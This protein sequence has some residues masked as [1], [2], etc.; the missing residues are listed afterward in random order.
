MNKRGEDRVVGVIWLFVILLVGLILTSSV[1]N[2]ANKVDTKQ[3]FLNDSIVYNPSVTPAS[4]SINTTFQMNITKAQT[5]WRT[6]GCPISGYTFTNNN[7]TALTEN[8][9]YVF[10]SATGN[11][12][13]LNTTKTIWMVTNSNNTLINYT[14][15]DSGYSTD[16]ATQALTSLI[17]TFMVVVL[18]V[19]G[20]FAVRSF[21]GE[22]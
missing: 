14:Y 11:F 15:C 9:D 20:A 8:T 17:Q 10:T 18:L 2:T 1:A 21:L 3:V 5:D 7:G 19:A 22:Q 12:T 6:T 16:S 4:P 13:L